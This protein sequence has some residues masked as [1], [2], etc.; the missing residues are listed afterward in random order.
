MM[1]SKGFAQKPVARQAFTLCGLLNAGASRGTVLYDPDESWSL[2][3][4]VTLCGIHQALPVA[5][6]QQHPAGL[7]SKFGRLDSLVQ[8]LLQYFTHVASRYLGL[9]LDLGWEAGHKGHLFDARGM[10]KDAFQATHWAY[11]NL[12]PRC[13]HVHEM[14]AVQVHSLKIL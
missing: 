12:I 6:S 8:Q 1:C 4:V 2:A 14:I 13:K 11:K 7:P 5:A 10:W 3:T 9:Q